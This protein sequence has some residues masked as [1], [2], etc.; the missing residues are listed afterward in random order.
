MR[1]SGDIYGCLKKERKV[2]RMKEILDSLKIE[3]SCNLDNRGYHSFFIKRSNAPK[4]LF[5][6]FPHEWIYQSTIHQ[7]DLIINEI[8]YRS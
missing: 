1:R 7:K 2:L 5:K 6:E 4:Y 8:L 3:Y